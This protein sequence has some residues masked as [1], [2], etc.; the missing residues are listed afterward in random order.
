LAIP[1]LC[2]EVGGL[3]RNPRGDF[4]LFEFYEKRCLR[5]LYDLNRIQSKKKSRPNPCPNW[6]LHYI[7]RCVCGKPKWMRC[8]R[9]VPIPPSTQSPIVHPA[10]IV[11]KTCDGHSRRYMGKKQAEQTERFGGRS[12]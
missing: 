12:Q 2:R 5:E 1:V 9:T 11:A 10:I 7:G 6:R 3:S 8:C 4:K